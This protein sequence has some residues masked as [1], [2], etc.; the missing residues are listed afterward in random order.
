MRCVVDGD[1]RA[2][3]LPDLLEQRGEE[4]APLGGVGLGPP[5]PREVLDQRLGAVEVGVGW[6][7]GALE[8][9]CLISVVRRD[10]P[11]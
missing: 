7:L 3:L 4:L 8:W 9:D 11:A 1:D 2:V 10:K 5:E 6:R